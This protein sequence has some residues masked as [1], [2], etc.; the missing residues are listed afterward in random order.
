MLAAGLT[1]VPYLIG[2]NAVQATTAG[3]PEYTEAV[4]TQQCE[5]LVFAAKPRFTFR[6]SPPP[7]FWLTHSC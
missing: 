1:T 6:A 7:S 5:G 3:T 4:K 2:N